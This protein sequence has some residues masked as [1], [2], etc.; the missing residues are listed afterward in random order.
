MQGRRNRQGAFHVG[1]D[2]GE[3][4]VKFTGR[5]KFGVPDDQQ[6][7]AQWHHKMVNELSPRT[8][9]LELKRR[10]AGRQK[11]HSVRRRD[12]ANVLYDGETGK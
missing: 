9:E 6:E 5:T 2:G 11:T 4:P 1:Y 3:G 10:A 8:L 12:Q 7:D